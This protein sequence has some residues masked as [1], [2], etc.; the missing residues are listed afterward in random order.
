MNLEVRNHAFHEA[1]VGIGQIGVRGKACRFRSRQ[2]LREARMLAHAKA[3]AKCIAA[4]SVDGERHQRVAVQ[5]QQ[6]G[7]VGRKQ[8]T[9][10]TQQTSIAFVVRQVMRE[11]L[12]Q[13]SQ[14]VE[15]GARSH[16]DLVWSRSD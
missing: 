2:Q 5:P 1:V 16:S 15:H 11:I 13:R 14:R 9:Q 4:Q 3:A 7:C 10:A 8:R 12:H 6:R